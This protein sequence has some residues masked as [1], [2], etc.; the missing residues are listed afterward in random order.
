MPRPF[1]SSSASTTARCFLRMSIQVLSA[2]VLQH[3]PRHQGRHVFAASN[4]S[5]NCARRDRERLHCYLGD[6]VA[7]RGVRTEAPSGACEYRDVAELQQIVRSVP[8]IELQVLVR[9]EKQ[10]DSRLRTE[11]RAE[12]DQGVDGEPGMFR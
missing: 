1:T 11:F 3:R 4:R 6:A 7:R 10:I 12:P 2:D 8:A 9:A 5:A